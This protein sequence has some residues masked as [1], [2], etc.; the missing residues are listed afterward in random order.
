MQSSYAYILA[1]VL[2]YLVAHTIKHFLQPKSKRSWKRWV[3]TGNF[4]SS[5]T[6]VVAALVTT[7]FV[8]E[9]ASTL[10]A[11]AGVFAAI[12]IQDSLSSRRSV[13]EQGTVLG[14]LLKKLSPNEPAPYVAIGHTLKEVVAGAVIGIVIGVIVA[15]F[16]T[17]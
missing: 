9:G 3:Q 13:G 12:T 5:H 7:I 16:I 2:G 4:P 11:V 8:H 14:K 1:A 6:A 10:F 15:L 17:I